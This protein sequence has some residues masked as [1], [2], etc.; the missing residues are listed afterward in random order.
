MEKEHIEVTTQEELEREPL[1]EEELAAVIES[2]I[3]LMERMDELEYKVMQSDFKRIEALNE[4]IAMI[5]YNNPRKR[6]EYK[7]WFKKNFK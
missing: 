2:G 7:K 1:G 6:R 3:K 5:N 4:M